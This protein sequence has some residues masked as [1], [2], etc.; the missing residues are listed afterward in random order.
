MIAL[1][2]S[3]PFVCLLYMAEGDPLYVQVQEQCSIIGALA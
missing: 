1:N 3:R 2:R